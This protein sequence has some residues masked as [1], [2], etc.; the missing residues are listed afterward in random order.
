M[1]SEHNA[2]QGDLLA[3]I[4]KTAFAGALPAS[5]TL[6]WVLFRL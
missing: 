1:T 6:N 4:L 3:A 2:I 5:L